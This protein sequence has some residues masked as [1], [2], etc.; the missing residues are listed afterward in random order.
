MKT[1]PEMIA[2]MQ[3][4]EENGPDSV[5]IQSLGFPP[6]KWSTL[7]VPRWN[8]QLFTY[9]IAETQDSID[10]THIHPDYK[11]MVRNKNGYAFLYTEKPKISNNYSWRSKKDDFTAVSSHA[12]Y[13]QGT[14]DWKDSLVCREE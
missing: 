3:H 8:W 12:S 2:V 9:R 5:E 1:I 6:A 11:W 13:K 4:F 14:C 10:W 7:A